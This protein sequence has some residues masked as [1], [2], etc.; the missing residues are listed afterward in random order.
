MAEGSIGKISLD[1]EVQGDLAKQI[2][3]VAGS[4]AQQLKKSVNSAVKDAFSGMN[5]DVKKSVDSAAKTVQTSMKSTS[6]QVKKDLKDSISVGVKSGTVET[7]DSMKQM[8]NNTASFVQSS[9]SKMFGKLRDGMRGLMGAMKLDDTATTYKSTNV[10]TSKNNIVAPN[11]TRGSPEESSKVVELKNKINETKAAINSLNQ[12]M[13]RLGKTKVPTQE[14]TQL[15]RT[16][17]KA[18]TTL[19]NLLNRQEKMED[20]GVKKNSASWK[21]LQYDIQTADQKLKNYE[22]AMANLKSSGG[23]FTAGT[24]SAGYT[25][26][27]SQLNSLIERLSAYKARLSEVQAKESAAAGI[28]LKFR[29]ILSGLGKSFSIALSGLRKLGSGFTTVV[30]GLKKLGSGFTSFISKLKQTVIHS[31]KT[32]SSVGGLGKSF[33]SLGN[34]LK[35]MVIRKALQ[36]IITG[37]KEGFQNLAQYS[38]EVNSSMSSL[39]NSLTKLKN[40]FAAA[41]APILNVVAPILTKFIDLLI[42]GI[43]YIG[44]FFSALTGAG[45]YNV[46]KDVNDDYA[47]SV[48]NAADSAADATEAAKEYQKTLMGFDKINKLDSQSDSSDTTSDT[49][50]TGTSAKD[51]FETVSVSGWA[52]DLADMVKNAWKNADFTEVGAMLGSKLNSALENI[53]W[54]KIQET[55]DKIAKSTATFLNGFIAATDW[56]L[57]GQTLATGINTIFGVANT[58]ATNFNWSNLGKA[59]G[60]GINGALGGLDWKLIKETVKNIVGGI[61]N[62]LNSFISTTD[63]SQ[64]GRTFA[65]VINTIILVGY[66]FVSTFNWLSFGL[67]IANA[68]N[69]ALKTMNLGLAAKTLSDGIKGFLNTITTAIRE[70]DW[71]LVGQQ[72]GDML[73]NIDW[74]GIAKGLWDAG[75]ALIGGLL[76]AF[77][78]LPAPVKVVINIITAFWTLMKGYTIVTTAIGAWNVLAGVASGVTTA[79]GAAFTFLIS[80]IGLIVLAIAAVIAI[81]VL[82]YK[83]WDTIKEQAIKI[84][85]A[86]KDWFEKTCEA[87]GGFF[88]GLWTGITNI[89]KDVGD[90]FKDKFETAKTNVQNAFSKVGEY[91]QNRWTDVKNAFS[92]VGA[93]FKEKFETAKTNT[94]NAFSKVGEYYQNRWTDIQN[95]FSSAGSWFGNKFGTAYSSATGAFS[96]VKS[97]F[98]NDVWGKITDVFSGSDTWFGN[99]FSTALGKIKTAFSNVFGAIKGIVKTPINAVIGIL[100]GLISGMGYAVNSISRMLNSLS[101]TIPSWVPGVGGSSWSPNL[102]TW[103]WGSIPYLA[104]GGVIDSPTLAM[105]GEAGKE[106]VM[107]LERNTGW[108]RNLAG[109]LEDH[110]SNIGGNSGI[111]KEEMESIVNNAVMRIIAALTDMSFNLDGEQMGKAQIKKQ[112]GIDRRW[113]TAKVT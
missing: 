80:P 105:V 45:S 61:T 2:Q 108:I 86:I 52:K 6:D 99:K 32:Q 81:G 27:Q 62:T 110:M 89:F 19:L 14:Y 12:D 4:I 44:M 30:S 78:E 101:I 65:D 17:K 1:L 104:T 90:W 3:E 111:T 38:G 41:F 26:K 84:W 67:A 58:F 29:S 103:T 88:K 56:E 76:D 37:T 39:M 34:M 112:V 100:N 5:Q 11:V 23:A 31:R 87:I 70:I 77:K 28:T 97:F 9:F 25:K 75:I 40:S 72:V 54:T 107:P 73:K 113:N 48:S 49:T 33:L 53:P 15:D 95:A 98:Q 18:E 35:M 57:V 68:I 109:Q 85:G 93:W 63:W 60:D 10:P 13:A 51:M 36:A 71:K 43:N 64:V 46:A 55:L 59:V 91:Y 102:Q 8:A 16:I 94:Q 7:E 22:T 92:N 21:G 96:N 74:L 50:A 79:L 66:T 69:G 42:K 24:D 82:L 83:N 20:T 47:A 106:A